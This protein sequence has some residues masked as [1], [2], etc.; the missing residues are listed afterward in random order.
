MPSLWSPSLAL[1]Q[2]PLRTP[3]QSHHHL[4]F[5]LPGD[6]H[7]YLPFTSRD[8]LRVSTPPILR[9][10][11]KRH[12][13]PY[14]WAHSLSPPSPHHAAWWDP[15]QWMRA[16]MAMVSRIARRKSLGSKLGHAQGRQRRWTLMHDDPCCPSVHDFDRP[17]YFLLQRRG[18][19]MIPPPVDYASDLPLSLPPLLPVPTSLRDRPSSLRPY[20]ERLVLCVL[21]VFIPLP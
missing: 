18:G 2:C 7:A 21:D 6:L 13:P 9:H 19:N 5:C 15:Y 3:I 16:K 11:S 20:F 8:P 14:K 4:L 10:H 17:P 1:P 12:L